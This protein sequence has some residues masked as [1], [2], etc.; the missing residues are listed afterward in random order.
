MITA[1]LVDFNGT[2]V[3]EDGPYADLALDRICAAG[4]EKDRKKVFDFWWDTFDRYTEDANTGVFRNQTVLLTEAFRD[5]AAHFSAGVDADELAGLIEEQWRAPVLFPDSGR[6]FKK[7]SLPYYI[8][9][10]GDDRVISIAV[11]SLG[12]TPAGIITSESAGA[13]KPDRR[14]FEMA[15][16]VMGER[17]ERV[18]MMGDSLR[19]DYLAARDM[20]MS[21]CLID[22]D[23]KYSGEAGACPGLDVALEKIILK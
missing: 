16:D 22:R 10:N 8:I 21:A 19:K 7:V 1:L 3:H 11:N 14:I 15:L 17:P 9:T 23:G 18:C 2:L 4:T 5:T 20:G 6:F 13:Y 12:I